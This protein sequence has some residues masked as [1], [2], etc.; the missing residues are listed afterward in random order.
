MI[1][2]LVIIFIVMSG[3]AFWLSS[4]FSSLTGGSS[5]TN[6][7]SDF[8]T[9]TTISPDSTGRSTSL[10]SDSTDSTGNHIHPQHEANRYRNF[11]RRRTD[12]DSLLPHH[13]QPQSTSAHN[14]YQDPLHR[15]HHHHSAC[16]CQ[17]CPSAFGNPTIDN[18]STCNISYIDCKP[19]DYYS[20]MRNSSPV[21]IVLLAD[22]HGKQT[23]ADLNSNF[24]YSRSKSIS[25]IDPNELFIQMS[26]PKYDELPVSWRNI[27]QN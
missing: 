4:T 11:W 14:H 24:N 6:Q 2:A 8:S 7:H 17:Q 3:L 21:D 26:P 13:H 20:A 23:N 1:I 19:P 16:Q 9:D 18:K 27:D 15:H 12:S 5:D 10:S 22:E 25:L